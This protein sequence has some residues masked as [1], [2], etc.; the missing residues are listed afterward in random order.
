MFRLPVVLRVTA[1]I[2]VSV[3][4]GGSRAWLAEASAEAAGLG[5][6]AWESCSGFAR[7][8]SVSISV[9]NDAHIT[10][11]T[12]LIVG[13]YLR[14]SVL[15]PCLGSTKVRGPNLGPL[16]SQR[17]SQPGSKTVEADSCGGESPEAK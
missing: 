4:L 16:S 3:W 17:P 5:L 11:L 15:S 8:T 7:T 9:T 12:R 14:A 2:A 13:S 1:A 10:Q 6:G